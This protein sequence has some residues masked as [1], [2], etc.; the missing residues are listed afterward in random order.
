MVEYEDKILDGRNRLYFASILKKPIRIE[1]FTGSEEEARRHV[2]ILNLH[3][4]HLSAQAYA[5]NV[6]R[7]KIGEEK[8]PLKPAGIS[9]HNRAGEWHQIV[10]RN[11]NAA[12]LDVTAN[13]IR[14]A[15]GSAWVS[16]GA[17][18]CSMS[19]CGLDTSSFRAFFENAECLK[20]GL[21]QLRHSVWRVRT[22]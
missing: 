18:L 13:G 4:R 7:P 15:A 2:V 8:S 3:R 16:A 1:K 10:V 21:A 19:S 11:A 20:L 17:A 6:G 12:G 5:S 9:T 14:S 22:R